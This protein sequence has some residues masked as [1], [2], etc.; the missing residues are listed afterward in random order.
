MFP[1]TQ[2]AYSEGGWASFRVRHLR[3]R[4]VMRFLAFS[5][6]QCTFSLFHFPFDRVDTIATQLHPPS[7]RP[8]S[9][10]CHSTQPI[11]YDPSL[12]SHVKPCHVNAQ[13]GFRLTTIGTHITD[14]TPDHVHDTVSFGFN[15]DSLMR[16]SVRTHGRT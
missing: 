1:T 5:T 15:R 10:S 11:G 3:T 8:T 14:V 7:A 12:G 16:S 9:A 4:K 13:F 6:Y 2:M